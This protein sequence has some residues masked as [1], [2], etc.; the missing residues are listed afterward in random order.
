MRIGLVVALLLCLAEM[1]CTAERMQWVR[2]GPDQKH[3]VL[4]TSG[5]RFVPW[6][7]NYAVNSSA[8]ADRIDWQ[9][10]GRDLDDF[11]KMRANVARVHLQVPH[12]M[13]GVNRPNPAALAELRRLCKLAQSKGIYL[14]IT[15]L[16]SYDIRKRAGWYDALSN[17]DRWETQACFW[18][19]VAGACADSPAVFCYDLMNEPVWGGEKKDGWYAG[20]MGNDEFVQRLSLGVHDRSVDQVCRQWTKKMVVAIRQCDQKHLITIG[21]LPAWGPSPQVV[22]PYLDFIAVH[23][24]PA[25]GKVD[26]SLATLKRFD[27]GRPIVVEETF[28]LSCSV[29]DE[30]DFLLRSRSLAAGWIGQ[31]PEESVGELRELRRSKKISPGQAM[32]LAWLDLFEEVGPQ[33]LGEDA[34]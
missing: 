13:L 31:Y 16:A 26:E 12:F 6:G 15:G 34:R 3:F 28:P 7:N 5:Q 27:I 14:D 17:E 22:G 19:A 24:Y 25:K 18:Q 33:M 4:G 10:I 8:S 11:R 21:M 2:V 1:G 32:Y 29:E 20:R 9:R 23:I 30:R